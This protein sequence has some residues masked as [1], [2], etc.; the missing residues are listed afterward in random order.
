MLKMHWAIQTALEK[1]DHDGVADWSGFNWNSL[2]R[3]T[4]KRA[5]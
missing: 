2:I 5:F 1:L 4:L 3:S